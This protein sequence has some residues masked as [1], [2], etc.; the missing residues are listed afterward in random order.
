MPGRRAPQPPL[1]LFPYVPSFPHV[2]LF[3]YAGTSRP[4]TA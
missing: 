2:P 1:P 3:P 4:T